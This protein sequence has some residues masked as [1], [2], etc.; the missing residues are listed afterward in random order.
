MPVM[1]F[2]RLCSAE[3]KYSILHSEM[4]ILPPLDGTAAM[5]RITRLLLLAAGAALAVLQA[6]P[7]APAAASVSELRLDWAFYNP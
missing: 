5:S 3:C 4:E 1:Y 6:L 7:V 2:Y